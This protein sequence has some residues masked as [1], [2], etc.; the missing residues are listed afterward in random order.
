M[1]LLHSN[2][3]RIMMKGVAVAFALIHFFSAD[4]AFQG[5]TR[6]SVERQIERHMIDKLQVEQ[7]AETP[8]KTSRL[9]GLLLSRKRKVATVSKDLVDEE[10]VVATQDKKV[11]K[12]QIEVQKDMVEMPIIT[13]KK[14]LLVAT[15][16]AVTVVKQW[17]SR[18]DV[19]V[20]KTAAVEVKKVVDVPVST[21]KVDLTAT[22]I[23]SKNPI[24]SVKQVVAAY[25]IDDDD[26]MSQFMDEG[27]ITKK[28]EDRKS[29][30]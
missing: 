25:D 26:F 30:V 6:L 16:A 17:E 10:K 11:I 14:P 12:K 13:H 27:A 28:G 20:M 29:V 9:G 5:L 22:V 15:K 23:N 21:K 24:K 3:F 8:K 2:T 18:K 4:D 7:P 19:V 1:R